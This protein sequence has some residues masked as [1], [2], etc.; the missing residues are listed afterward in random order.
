MGSG[1]RAQVVEFRVWCSGFI[2]SPGGPCPDSNAS[3]LSGVE[4]AR[5]RAQGAR[6]RIEGSVCRGK[7]LYA[8][9][10]I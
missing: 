5:F 7:I 8:G 10:R 1:C 9:C 4:G 3:F 6:C 2:F